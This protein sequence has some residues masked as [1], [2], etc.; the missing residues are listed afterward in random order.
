VQSDED[1]R[2]ASKSA[3]AKDAPWRI[4]NIPVAAP[5]NEVAPIWP[6]MTKNGIPRGHAKRN[7]DQNRWNE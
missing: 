4:V 5:A 1:H 2:G 6:A 7:G 3:E